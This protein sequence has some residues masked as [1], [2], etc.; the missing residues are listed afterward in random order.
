[1]EWL[2][3]RFTAV[4]HKFLSGAPN[5]FYNFKT[6][7]QALAFPFPTVEWIPVKRERERERERKHRRN[8]I[9]AK[10]PKDM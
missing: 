6:I 4:F 7:S 3:P 1:V 8:T 2:K 5:H 10:G 9:K